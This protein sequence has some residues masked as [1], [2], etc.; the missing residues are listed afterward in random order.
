MDTVIWIAVVLAAPLLALGLLSGTLVGLIG[1]AMAWRA[2]RLW[3][4]ERR[5]RARPRTP[6]W[7]EPPAVR[8]RP[9]YLARRDRET[10]RRDRWT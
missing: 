9:S 3:C 10:G 2:V 5:E 6:R 1:A 8:E 7:A 4:R